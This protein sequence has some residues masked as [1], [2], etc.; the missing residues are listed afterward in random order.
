MGSA[1]RKDQWEVGNL[2]FLPVSGDGICGATGTQGGTVKQVL[3][4]CLGFP[5]KVQ[6][7]YWVRGRRRCFVT[8]P[9]YTRLGRAALRCAS[10]FAWV[11]DLPVG[12]CV[13][14]SGYAL[15]E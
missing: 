2:F 12:Y 10:R 1:V 3:A 5:R 7:G 4:L 6:A 13:H 11:L 9:R 15:G 14:G 8:F